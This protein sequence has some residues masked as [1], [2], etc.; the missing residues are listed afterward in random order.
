[1]YIETVRSS[2]CLL[3][4]AAS[5]LCQ[6]PC[7]S[8]ADFASAK[9]LLQ[10]RNYEGAAATLNRLKGCGNLS[11]LQRFELGWLYGRARHF[12]EALSEFQSV[13]DDVPD[14]RS[15]LYAVALSEFELANYKGAVGALKT[16]ET[17]GT[18]NPESANLLAVSYSKLALYEQAQSTLTEEIQRHREDQPAYL[19]LVT[20]YA[21]QDRYAEA[22][23]IASDAVQAFPE[24]AEV[25]VVRGAANTLTGQLDKAYEDFSNAIRLAP[26]WADPRFFLALTRYKQGK[27]TDAI[28]ALELANQR[29]IA[30][31]DLHYL[32]AECLLKVN[33]ANTQ[34]AMRELDK[35]VELNNDSVSARALRGKLRLEAG[36]TTEAVA[37]LQRA[38]G[39]DPASRT[40]AYNLA[41]AYQKLGRREDARLIFEQLRSG[42]TDAV[43]ELSQRRLSEVL[44]QKEAQP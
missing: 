30:D 16:L 23:K 6:K 19:N 36:S 29:G 34:A 40:A 41:R 15:H 18:L 33:A 21:D 14:R 20:L 12:K 4:C 39:R 28:N 44:I 25:L 24:S 5:L 35:A 17:E 31:S 10:T 11:P 42:K 38:H 43:G 2:V 13:P 3:V 1:M 22:A 9:H 37:D 7:D 27:F 26:D 8:A 32:L